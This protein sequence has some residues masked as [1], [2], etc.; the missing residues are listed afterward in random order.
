MRALWLLLL[1]GVVAADEWPRFRGPNGAGVSEEKSIP[2]TWTEKDFAW[3]VA[4]PGLGHSSPVIWG[5]RVFL[6]S[7]EKQTG[8]RMVLA[9]DL[10]TG[11]QL[12]RRDLDGGA[13]YK[14]HNAN[15][16][17]TS[18]PAVDAERLYTRLG[19]TRV[20]VIPNYALY[21]DGRPCD[22]TVF[23]KAV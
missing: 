11:K 12:W 16:F 5:G 10:T 14:T 19:W 6:T 23:W 3:R 18:T 13:K 8:R 15:S 7:A 9:H 1:A 17:A 21:P 22:T 20:G 4:V 2:V